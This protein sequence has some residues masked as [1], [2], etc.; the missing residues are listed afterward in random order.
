MPTFLLEHDPLGVMSDS[1][2]LADSGLMSI[3]EDTT[4]HL[5]SDESVFFVGK[6]FSTFEFNLSRKKVEAYKRFQRVYNSI[7]AILGI[8]T[9]YFI[10]CYQG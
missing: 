6:K 4:Q 10:Y 8:D 1:D 5:Y 7:I 9:I 3:E 2:S